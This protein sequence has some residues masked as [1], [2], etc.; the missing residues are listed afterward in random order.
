VLLLFG[1]GGSRTNPNATVR[2]TVAR[3][4]LDG[5]DTTISAPLG[6]KCKSAPVSEK[7]PPGWVA[8][9]VNHRFPSRSKM[10]SAWQGSLPGQ[11][12]STVRVPRRGR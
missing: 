2:W 12:G 3:R 1:A 11:Q 5:D 9:C 6:Q 4:R 7:R 8:F 10:P